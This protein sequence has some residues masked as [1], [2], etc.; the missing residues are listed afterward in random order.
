MKI[1]LSWQIFEEYSNV[2]FHENLFGGSG[3]ISCGWTDGRTD[4]PTDRHDEANGHFS[5]FYERV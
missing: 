5:Q 3:V 1:E 4:G 2:K